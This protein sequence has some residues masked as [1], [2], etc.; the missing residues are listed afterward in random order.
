MPPGRDPLVLIG[1]GVAT[2]LCIVMFGI[3]TADWTDWF[4]HPMRAERLGRVPEDTI[5]GVRVLRIAAVLA[6][7]GWLAVPLILNRLRGSLPLPASRPPESR[8]TTLVLL[9][10]ITIVAMVLRTPRLLESL[11][12]DEIAAFIATSIHGVGP[13][14]GN[15]HALANHALHSALA[16]LSFQAFGDVDAELALRLPAFLAGVACVPAMFALGRSVD[17]DRLG[18]VAATILAVMP[19]AILESVESRGYAFMILFAILATH[20]WLRLA[21]GRRDAVMWYALVVSA[22]VWSHLVFACV[23]LGHA[24]QGAIRTV[25]HPEDRPAGVAWFAALVLGGVTTLLVVAP[26]IP[27]I[28]M[29]RTEFIALDGDEPSVFGPE[30]LHALWQLGGSWT[31]WTAIPGLGL[32]LF[33]L[34][35]S[36][37]WPRLRLASYAG[38]AG[39]GVCLVATIAGDSWL[40]ARFLLFLVAPA[41]LLL[42][43]ALCGAGR[44]LRRREPAIL[45]GAVLVVAWG[46]GLASLPPKQPIR[47]GVAE[48]RGLA[49]EEGRAWSI[50]LGDD[51]A[52]FYAE[53][54]GPELI[55][56]PRLGRDL[57]ATELEVGPDAVVML[58]PD[59][60]PAEVLERLRVAGFR[61]HRR[62]DGWLDWGRGDVS[63]WRRDP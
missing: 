31:W 8:R 11:W 48:A 2:L 49:G 44:F 17:D 19:V 10:L 55:H 1:A 36:W 37:R 30:G 50:G 7:L 57:G 22:G 40:Y 21:D 20:Q 26:L 32:L 45:A 25:R 14:L 41:T 46:V 42:A 28:L 3:G 6:A 60:V 63:V 52:M 16:S 24:V 34:T 29:N 5:Q 61:E 35:E 9:V 51:V 33:G 39:G 43:A 13:S 47:E 53:G 59:L 58:Y 4:T 56:A 15:Y 38:L 12:Y 27:G 23:P 62:L 54:R 18:L